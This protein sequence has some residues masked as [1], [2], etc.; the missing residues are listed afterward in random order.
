MEEKLI[1]ILT[2]LDLEYEAVL[3]HIGPVT[4]HRYRGGTRA[5]IGRGPGG[6][7]IALTNVGKGNTSSAALTTRIID[8][9]DPAAV[10][11]SGVGG[12]RRANIVLGDVVVA[13]HV[14]HYQGGTSTDTGFKAR[15]RVFP[16]SHAAE[17]IA[18]HLNR[19]ND[20]RKHLRGAAHPKVHFG[21]IA[22]GEILLDSVTSPEA[23]LLFEHYNDTYAVEM[24]AAG[25]LQAAHMAGS[26]PTVVVRGIS[27]FADGRKSETDAR[28]SQPNAAAHAAAFA[29][30]LA[31]ELA[32]LDRPARGLTREDRTMVG[33]NQNNANGNARVGVQTGVFAGSYTFHEVD[34]IPVG[35][36]F[37]GLRAALRRAADSGE[38]DTTDHGAAIAELD[39]AES[40]RATDRAAALLA[41][42]RLRGFIFALPGPAG[43]LSALITDLGDGR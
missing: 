40:L 38:L 25:V 12:S 22:A 26:L 19:S 6:C 23:I 2:A 32:T 36:A 42:K 14:Y 27:D 35:D 39:A 30:A 21:P 28:D 20:W 1:V 3:A 43:L 41:L 8:E 33:S 24:E 16:T 13:S 7:R 34:A 31:G 29:F 37:A 9:A 15:P 17:Q 10:I 11:F 5:E 18:H 4:P